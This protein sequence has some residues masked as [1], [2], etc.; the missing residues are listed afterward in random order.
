MKWQLLPNS[1]IPDESSQRF[2]DIHFLNATTGYMILYAG[3]VYKTTNGGD[4]WSNIYTGSDHPFS[5]YRSI[6][7]FNSQIGLLGTL[8]S[9][10][11]LKRTTNGGTTWTNSTT[12]NPVP[13]G[14][15]GISIV[16][17]SVA[18]ACGRY[19]APANVIRTT[20]KGVSWTSIVMNSSLVSSLIDCYFWSK[21]SGIVVGGFNTSS[22]TVGKSVVMR[23]TNGGA[24]WQRTYISS[25]TEEWGWKISFV[26]RDV[27]YVS[28]ERHT[29]LAYI[30]KTT[31]SGLDWAE[32]VFRTYDEEGIGFI[33]EN[34]GWIG[35]W[36][37][38]TF[39]TTNGGNNWYQTNWGYYINRFRFINDT[40]AYAVG[41]RVY[42][43]LRSSEITPVTK[44]AAI[45]DYGKSGV[46]ELA[47]ADYVKSWNP[48]FIITLGNNNYD[49]W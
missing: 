9:L 26:S 49:I 38:P 36:T 25:R 14:I 16:N 7:F 34:T 13:Y 48:D 43:Y 23:T 41:D 46:N 45:G 1:P 8:N 28:I 32:K 31:N 21:D 12:P 40:L 6:G 11:P 19:A 29:G 3:R 4:N 2:E 17:D 33:N 22:Y 18:F 30:I 37:G 24:T 5:K 35:G 47:V 15:C 42:K 27:G 10:A 44:F 39:K 20:N